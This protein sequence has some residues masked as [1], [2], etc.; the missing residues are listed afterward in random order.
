MPSALPGNYRYLLVTLLCCKQT[1]ITPLF[2]VPP[3]IKWSAAWNPFLPGICTFLRS[4][5]SSVLDCF[6]VNLLLADN[7]EICEAQYRWLPGQACCTSSAWSAFI[8]WLSTS[9][10]T[11][12]S[13]HWTQRLS[14]TCLTSPSPDPFGYLNFSQIFCSYFCIQSCLRGT[15][16]FGSVSQLVTLQISVLCTFAPLMF[17]HLERNLFWHFC[18]LPPLQLHVPSPTLVLTLNT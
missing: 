5:P 17:S 12:S 6:M 18:T 7:E 3:W 8:A 11:D 15:Y 1:L 9:S 10:L 13:N 14:T 2:T 16:L 4:F